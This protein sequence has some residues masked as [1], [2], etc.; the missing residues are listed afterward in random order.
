[1][2]RDSAALNLNIA[3][4]SIDQREAFGAFFGAAEAFRACRNRRSFRPI[5]LRRPK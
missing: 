3:I 5:Q 1:M 2:P 4:N